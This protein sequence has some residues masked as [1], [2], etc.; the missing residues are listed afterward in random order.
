[1]DMRLS[2]R[3]HIKYEVHQGCFHITVN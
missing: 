3:C 2:K 1:N